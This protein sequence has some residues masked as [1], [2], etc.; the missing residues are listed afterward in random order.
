MKPEHKLLLFGA[1]AALAAYL[2]R[3][4]IY[5]K[6]V[7]STFYTSSSNYAIAHP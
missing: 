1:L 5:D 3:Y 6:P 2:L 4:Y 7:L